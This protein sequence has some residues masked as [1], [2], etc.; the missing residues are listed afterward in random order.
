MT[1]K[2]CTLADVKTLQKVCR[3]TFTETFEEQ[4]TKEDMEK[5]LE[6]SYGLEILERELSDVNSM[7]YLALN[8]EGKALGYLKLNVGD[9]QTEEGYDDSLEIQRIYILKEAKG[10]GIGTEFM[11]IA[12]KTAK[13]MGLSYIWLGVWEFNYAA[14]KFYQGKGFTKFSEHVFVLGDDRQADFLMKKELK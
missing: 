10:Q 4:N 6:E 7:T 2:K 14:Q 1:I 5:F 3:D 8:D 13:D 11:K 9:A 12:E